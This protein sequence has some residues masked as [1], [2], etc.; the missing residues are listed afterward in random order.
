MAF[1][2][3]SWRICLSVFGIIASNSSASIPAFLRFFA[4]SASAA[5]STGACALELVLFFCFSISFPSVAK[6]GLLNQRAVFDEAVSSSKVGSR[7]FL[8]AFSNRRIWIAACSSGVRGSASKPSSDSLEL[9]SPWSES[10]SL[11][12][13]F[14]PCK[15]FA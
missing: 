5:S 4:F 10:L 11:S 9:V 15:S 12:L 3:F 14:C 8:G 13:S 6:R 1:S 2:R 7:G